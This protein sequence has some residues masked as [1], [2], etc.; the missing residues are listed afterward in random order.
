MKYKYF[1]C[2][3]IVALFVN[4]IVVV[5]LIYIDFI[6]IK[7]LKWNLL[8]VGAIFIVA[9][10]YIRILNNTIIIGL[11]AVIDAISKK[12][13]VLKGKC[14]NVIPLYHT[15]FLGKRGKKGER[16]ERTYYT[17]II[18][19]PKGIVRVNSSEYIDLQ[20]EKKYVFKIGKLSRIVLELEEQ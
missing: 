19:T 3:F 5:G 14:I 12:T 1:I 2:D 6:S 11:K 15:W 4:M 7:I 13:S 8:T 18:K 9:C 16:I 10:Y 20:M 17:M